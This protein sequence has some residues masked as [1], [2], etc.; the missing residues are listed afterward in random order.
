MSEQKIAELGQ[1]VSVIEDAFPR[2]DL[3]K[4]NV[5]SHRKFHTD[6]QKEDERISEI[7]DAAIKQIALWAL[8]LALA[9]VSAYFGF[10]A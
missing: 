8:A 9:G 3:G 2:D 6:E 1:R 10:K 7:K 5:H 4:P